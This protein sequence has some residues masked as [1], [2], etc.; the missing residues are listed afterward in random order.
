MRFCV[1][2]NVIYT[3]AQEEILESI[4]KLWVTPETDERELF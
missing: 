2:Y 4:K 3:Q 1:F